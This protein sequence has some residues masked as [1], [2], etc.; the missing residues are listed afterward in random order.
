MLP[1]IDPTTTQSWKKLAAHYEKMKTVHMKSL[2][3][4]DPE[5][6]AKFSLRFNDI[7]VD[8]S[9][10]IIT[11]ETMALLLDLAEELSLQ[12]AIEKMF[13]GDVI[14]E[15][16]NRAVLHV[17][18]RNRSNNPIYVNG[19]DVMPEVNAVVKQDEGI[20]AQR[21]FR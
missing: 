14:N 18:L 3:A 21:H 10:N 1:K 19:K 17:A 13:T 6:F 9:K 7:L 4:G 15:T 16:E 20:F 8:Y 2:F 5:R 12:E 11:G